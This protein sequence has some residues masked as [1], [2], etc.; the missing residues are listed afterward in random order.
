M[1]DK[2]RHILSVEVPAALL[3]KLDAAAEEANATRSQYVRSVLAADLNDTTD[4]KGG[5]A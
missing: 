1:E 3:D 2:K 4:K 5:D